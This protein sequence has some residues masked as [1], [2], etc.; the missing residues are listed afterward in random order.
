MRQNKWRVYIKPFDVDGALLSDFIEVTEDVLLDS[1]GKLQQA[2]DSVDYDVGIFRNSSIS[3]KLRNDHGYYSDIDVAQSIFRYKRSGSHV[4]IT[5]S[6]QTEPALCGIA[7]LGETILNE[8][9]EHEIFYGLLNDESFAM[10]IDSQQAAFQVLGRESILD[11]MKVPVGSLSNGDLISEVVYDCLNDSRV[12]SLVTLDIANISISTDVEVTDV[13]KFTNKTIK[14]AF[15]ELLVAGNSVMY[16]KNGIIYVKPRTAT[17]AVQAQFYGQASVEGVE[18]IQAIKAIKNGLS[19]TFNLWRWKDTSLVAEDSSSQT[20]YGVRD[21][22]LNFDWLTDNTDRQ[23]VLTALK[24]EFA[25]PKTELEL[26]TPFNITLYDLELLDRVTIDYPTVYVEG[27]QEVPICGIAVCGEAVLPRALWSFTI[28]DSTPFKI[29]GKET[30]MKNGLLKF[31][32][33]E[34]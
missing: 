28:D 13:S 8:G 4:K 33:R 2:L 22:E 24:N 12:T 18:N 27:E 1:L 9:D 16:I 32:L 29:I 7:I 20:L 15:E 5:Y 6:V 14:T 30:D 19:R 31:K 17:A 21:K 23:T 34:I 25:N 10:D 3:I 26:Y 11:R